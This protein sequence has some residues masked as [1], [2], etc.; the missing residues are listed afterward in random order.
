MTD[1]DGSRDGNGYRNPVIPGFHPD[2]SVCRA[3]DR[4]VLAVSSFTYFPG[5]PIFT[6]TDLVTWTQVGNVLDRVSQ[7][8][9]SGT[10]DFSSGGVFAPTIR[11][12]DG[13]F[14]MITTVFT[15]SGV[16]NFFVTAEDPAGPLVGTGPRG[17]ARHRP[18]PRVG[19]RRELLGPPLG[20]RRRHPA[21]PDR[22]A[23][24]CGARRSRSR[25]GGDGLAVP[26][27]APP[28][29]ARRVVVPADR[30]GRDRTRPRRVDRPRPRRRRVRGTAARP[31]R[32]S[33]TGAPIVRS[34]TPATATSST[35]STGRR[36]WSCSARGLGASRRCTTSS[37]ARPSSS[38]S[39]GSTGGRYRASSCS[40]CRIAP[41]GPSTG[42]PLARRDDFDASVAGPAVGVGPRAPR[43]RRVRHRTAGLAHTA[44]P[45]RR[46]RRPSTGVRRPAPAA[47]PV[48]RPRAG[49]GR[50]RR[51][52]G[53]R[54]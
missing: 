20:G 23:D 31:T 13:R 39:T 1:G 52:S 49:R 5:V 54:A 33:A 44:G 28:V 37:G 12:H 4:F 14:W 43:R 6:S 38:R 7:L 51:R 40:T 36:G 48:P 19:R 35:R 34:R 25:M 26:G 45:W 2:P 8:D 15:A 53:S 17:G 46:S 41:P 10:E 16:A 24:G 18:R 47:P 9:L 22:R 11:Y 27:G 30:R 42:V 50:R 21:V 3:G 29:P 32:S